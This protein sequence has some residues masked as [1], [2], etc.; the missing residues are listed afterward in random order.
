MKK[1]F[2]CTIVL[3]ALIIVSSC[4]KDEN[5]DPA[6]AEAKISMKIDGVEW[7]TTKNIEAFHTDVNNILQI[8]GAKDDPMDFIHISTVGYQVG[9]YPM[10]IAG[11]S[12]TYKL[13]SSIFDFS[14]DGEIAITSCDTVNKIVSGTFRFKAVNGQDLSSKLITEGKF[15][16][17]KFT[18][19]SI[20][21]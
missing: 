16:N 21:K 11:N 3:I 1:S 15:E 12:C 4:K 18:E 8:A 5:G 19:Q 9:T 17:I 2:I 14:R 10:T 20:A 6:T 7:T 13:Y